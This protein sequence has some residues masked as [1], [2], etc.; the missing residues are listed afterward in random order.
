M[1]ESISVSNLPDYEQSKLNELFGVWYDKR[2]RNVLRSVYYDGKAPLKD[3]GISIPPKMK[4]ISAVLDWPGKGVRALAHRNIFDSYV[5]QADDPFALSELL[6]VNRFD[7]ELPQA[8][9]SAYKHSCSFLTVAPGDTASGEPDVV[10]MP[11]SAEW[12]A[13]TWDSRRRMVASALAIHAVDDKGKPTEFTM[14]LPDS[15]IS[16]EKKAR[17][18]VADF[19]PNP[20]GEVLVEPLAYD[21]QV[22]RPFGRSRISR[23]AMSITDRAVRSIVRQET[24]A[25]FFSSPQR[26]VMGADKDAFDG[27]D[28]DRWSAIM[29]R[30]LAFSKD[31]DGGTP[32]V[33]QFPQMSMQP[34]TDML[35]QVASEFA[36]EMN[37]PVSALGIVQDNPA[38]AEA[39]YAAN[40]NLVIEAQYQNKVFTP[41]LLGVARKAIM[42]RDG[43]TVPTT[44]MLALQVKWANPSMPSPVSASD[45]L[46]K[47]A[48]VFP[49]IGESPVALEMAGF[50]SADITRLLSDKQRANGSAVLSRLQAAQ[51]VSNQQVK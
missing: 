13:A 22:D 33:G 14:Y 25:E 18:Y 20:L 5:G 23:S 24:T 43:F 7:V 12:T 29:G 47:L 44:E 8:I 6:T 36:A 42:L 49:W 41:A 32:T 10:I 9:V 16:I 51:T 27:A 26:W 28:A 35:R 40:E 46:V 19:R 31:E 11:R 3:A 15:V 1:S 48:T 34:H 50:T 4:R 37:M 38:S 21:P 45:A 30:V 2:P 17:V 39:M